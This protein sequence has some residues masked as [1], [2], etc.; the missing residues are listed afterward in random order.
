ML[1]QRQIVY[2]NLLKPKMSIASLLLMMKSQCKVNLNLNILCVQFTTS[3]AIYISG[4]FIQHIDIFHVI[5]CYSIYSNSI[6]Y[7]DFIKSTVFPRIQ[8]VFPVLF[9][10]YDKLYFLY[11]SDMLTHGN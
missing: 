7:K 8:P 6:D 10:R 11:I 2:S 9:C 1:K 3:S 5:C 4:L